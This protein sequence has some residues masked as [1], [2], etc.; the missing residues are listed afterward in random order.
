MRNDSRSTAAKY[1]DLQKMPFDDIPFYIERLS[2][3]EAMVLELGCGTGRVLL[4][5][6]EH[7]GYIH[8]LDSSKA[9]LDICEEKLQTENVHGG[10]A[11]IELAD[12]T[13]FDL[14]RKFDLIVAP[15]R[16]FQNL[17]TDNQIDGF[18]NCVRKHLAPGG[19]CILN[20]FKPLSSREALIKEWTSSKGENLY[21]E[22]AIDGR[23]ITAHERRLR[24]DKDKCVLYPALVYRVY[25]AD[26]IKD[27]AVLKIAMRCYW[28]DE[29]AELI[30]GYGFEITN[31]WGGYAGETYG[32]GKEL[33]I[34]FTHNSEGDY[35]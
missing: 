30:T 22:M 28:P 9:M 26:V 21:S 1:Y 32:Q 3:D 15:Y 11:C 2:S 10:N 35:R 25:E 29:F 34:Q 13:G 17:E 4:A 8:G 33:V 23:R 20:V 19:S 12:I 5:L 14:D 24:I 31:H 6:A 16:V 27:E 18:F 7:C